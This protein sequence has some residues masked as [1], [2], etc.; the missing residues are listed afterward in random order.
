MNEQKEAKLKG[1]TKP[2]N[3]GLD[4]CTCQHCLSNNANGH[5]HEINHGDYKPVNELARNELNRV[6]LPGDVDYNGCCLPQVSITGG[7][8]VIIVNE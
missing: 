6:C 3:Y 5:K 8:G 2:E 1:V 7:D 4:N